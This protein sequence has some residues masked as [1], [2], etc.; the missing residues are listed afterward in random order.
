M[1]LAAQDSSIILADDEVQEN[2][3]HVK[4][5]DDVEEISF[6]PLQPRTREEEYR[7]QRMLINCGRE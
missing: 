3:V 2:R 6:V 7:L 5:P 1:M 4:N